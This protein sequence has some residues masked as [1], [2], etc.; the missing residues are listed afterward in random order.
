MKK[1]LLTIAIVFAVLLVAAAA[2][3]Y[4]FKDQIVAK[5]KSVINQKVNAKVDF[6][7]FDLTLIRSFPKMGI[8]LNDLSVVGIDSFANDTLANIKQLQLDLT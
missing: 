1:I 7:A 3:P 5:V 6:K 2:I 8:R 4:L